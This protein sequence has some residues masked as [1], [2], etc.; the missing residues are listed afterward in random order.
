MTRFSDRRLDFSEVRKEIRDQMVIVTNKNV[1]E[2]HQKN[3]DYIIVSDQYS[4]DYSVEMKIHELNEKLNFTK[5]ICFE[6]TD[7]LR[8]AIIR[9]RLGIEGLD[10]ETSLLYRDK[11]FM[12]KKVS[13]SG[14]KCPN[15]RPIENT[16]DL[17][18]FVKDHGYP[19][20]LKP[21]SGMIGAGNKT[22]K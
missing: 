10:Y 22:N 8:A 17:L 13:A 1:F 15:F 9:E 21:R 3:F 19:I 2:N 11:Y 6:E 4:N 7:I 18:D 12:K 14:I 20:F 16:F 5:L